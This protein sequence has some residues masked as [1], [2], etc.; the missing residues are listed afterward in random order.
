[1]ITEEMRQALVNKYEFLDPDLRPEFYK[2]LPELIS[3][4]KLSRSEISVRTQSWT[5]Y[6]H[7]VKEL[8]PASHLF[9]EWKGWAKGTSA[10]SKEQLQEQTADMIRTGLPE[11]EGK[12]SFSDPYAVR[13]LTMEAERVANYLLSKENKK[14]SYTWKD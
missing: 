12:P 10:F 1:M 14:K 13:F 3:F 4:S 9:D 11:I 8:S 6:Y 7:R 5:V 2:K